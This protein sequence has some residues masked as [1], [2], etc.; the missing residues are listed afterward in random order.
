MIFILAMLTTL[1]IGIKSSFLGQV[2]EKWFN[3]EAFVHFYYIIIHFISNILAFRENQDD[4]LDGND[5]GKDLADLNFE[6]LNKIG[7]DWAARFTGGGG[8]GNTY[9]CWLCHKSPH[10]S[11]DWYL[12]V[13]H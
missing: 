4:F 3:G 9:F 6:E 12:E 8:E 5:N 10:L 11:Q 1:V 2:L 7:E 13:K